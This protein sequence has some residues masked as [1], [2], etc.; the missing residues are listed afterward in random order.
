M[1]ALGPASAANEPVGAPEHRLRVSSCGLEH[2][3]GIPRG[4]LARY[5]GFS[6]PTP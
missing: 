1:T 3:H 6:L 5:E 2:H 4:A